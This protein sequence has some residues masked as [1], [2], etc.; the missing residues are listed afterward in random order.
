MSLMTRLSALL[1]ARLNANMLYYIP[2][3]EMHKASLPAVDP[4]YAS[5]S[6]PPLA[7][8]Q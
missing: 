7:Q 4:W 6:P 8:A 3:V 2:F 5:S 1:R